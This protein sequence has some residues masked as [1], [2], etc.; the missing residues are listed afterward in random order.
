MPGQTIE[1]L[2]ADSVVDAADA[3]KCP[4]EVLNQLSEPGLPPHKLLLKEG[5]PVMLLWNLDPKKG[6]C[7]G[8]R[9]RVKSISSH[10]VFCTYLDRERAGP[11]API[12]GVV[13]LPHI[14]CKSSEDGSFVEFDR[15]QFPIRVCFAMTTN[16][17]QG[18]SLGRQGG[19]LLEPRGLLSWP[20]LRVVEQSYRPE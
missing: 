15:K 12:D 18:Q 14:C 9:L 8:T 4:I 19:R 16:K 5:C 6:L 13:L 10:V 20:A 11:G 1:K 2:S 7:N 3:S 17:S